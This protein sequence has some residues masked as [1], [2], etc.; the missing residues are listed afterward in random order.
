M[1]SAIRI[2]SGRMS[3]ITSRQRTA[4]ISERLIGVPAS[5]GFTVTRSAIIVM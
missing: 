1:T 5:A 4:S 3:H 2:G